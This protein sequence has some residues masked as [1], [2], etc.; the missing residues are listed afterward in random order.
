MIL[1]S[2]KKAGIPPLPRKH[3]FGKTTVGI[4]LT[5]RLFRVKRVKKQPPAFAMQNGCSETY[6]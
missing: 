4:K 6:R 1:L 3:N 2:H 5:P